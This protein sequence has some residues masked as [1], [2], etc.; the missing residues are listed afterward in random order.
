M[1]SLELEARLDNLLSTAQ[2]E[3]EDID[4]FAPIQEREECPICMIPLPL[5]EG[6][7][8]FMSCCGKNI[9]SGCIFKEILNGM[10]NGVK[11]EKL[12]K[13]KK[14]AFCRQPEGK[15][16]I[17]RLKKLMKKKNPEAFIQMAKR[18]KLG[19]GMFQSDTKSLQ[20]LIHAAEL[21]S[22]QAHGMI[23]QYHEEGL[24][25]EQN[26]SKALEFYEVAAKQGY[27]YAHKLLVTFNGRN[28]NIQKAIEHLKV[29]AS[30]GDQEAMDSLMIGYKDKLLPKEEL[31][32]TLRECQASANEMKST[33]RENTR[34]VKESREKG[35]PIPIHLRHLFT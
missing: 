26:M 32:Q 23:G 17:K 34:L 30:A 24:A 2:K 4:L 10:K 8:T 16:H 3:T 21:D 11:I 9:C 29:A 20:M 19:E 25:V 5:D 7:I 6:D 35:E 1:A 33:D 12:H 28:G 22:A 18:Y 14:C 15:N 27:F 31:T 13:S